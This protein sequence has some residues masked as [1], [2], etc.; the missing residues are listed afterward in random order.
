MLI[1][2]DNIILIFSAMWLLHAEFSK[3]MIIVR[4]KE[5]LKNN[6]CGIVYICK[7][8]GPSYNH[9]TFTK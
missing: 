2:S 6:D 1:S 5:Q 9:H 3:K 7:D 8:N 4:C